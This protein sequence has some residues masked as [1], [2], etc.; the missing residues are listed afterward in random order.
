MLWALA[1]EA[2]IFVPLPRGVCQI[3]T[4]SSLSFGAL[5]TE[6]L[7]ILWWQREMGSADVALP[8][9]GGTEGGTKGGT[10]AVTNKV[11]AATET[12]K[13]EVCEIFMCQVGKSE[14]NRDNG[15]TPPGWPALQTGVL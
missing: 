4:I 15:M 2:F 5:N 8:T 12:D 1:G 9:E 3:P 14:L 7:P 11:F 13:C 6:M 10:K